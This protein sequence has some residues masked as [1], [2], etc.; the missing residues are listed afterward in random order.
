MEHVTG[1][2]ARRLLDEMVDYD[3]RAEFDHQGDSNLCVAAPDLAETVAWLYGREH[4]SADGDG[5]VWADK[6]GGLQVIA[7]N[8]PRQVF[9]MDDEGSWAYTPDEAVE[10]ARALLAAAEKARTM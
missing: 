4:T 5:V 8:C 10:L 9:V 1:D 6:S 7:D 3:F 2:Q